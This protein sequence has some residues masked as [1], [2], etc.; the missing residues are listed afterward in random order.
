VT[1]LIVELDGVSP[2]ISGRLGAEG[3]AARRFNGWLGLIAALDAELA[4]LG[5]CAATA[6]P[7]ANRGGGG[8]GG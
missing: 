7:S 6:A 5:T 8:G 3:A 4:R 1:R 2:Q